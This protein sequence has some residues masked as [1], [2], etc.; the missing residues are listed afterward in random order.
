MDENHHAVLVEIE[1]LWG[2]PVG[3]PEGDKLDALL[4]LVETY[5]E[6]RWPFKEGTPV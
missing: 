4:A 1:K 6:L 3:T 2:A 5:E